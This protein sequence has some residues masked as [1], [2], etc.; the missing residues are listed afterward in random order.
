VLFFVLFLHTAL[1]RNREPF[2]VFY[3]SQ[4]PL[5]HG[6]GLSLRLGGGPSSAS[7]E[8]MHKS[9]T[10]H[11]PSS[12]KC[13]YIHNKLR[14]QVRNQP[15]SFS[16]HAHSHRTTQF[17]LHILTPTPLFPSRNTFQQQ[18]QVPSTTAARSAVC[19]CHRV[20]TQC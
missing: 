13:T 6:I 12:S 4:M 15:R 19:T 7:I 3:L 16:S 20:E 1:D 14:T 9:G 8:S 2:P 5:A 17:F 11:S 18:C 10:L